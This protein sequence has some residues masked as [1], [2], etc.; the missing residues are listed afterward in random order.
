LCSLFPSFIDRRFFFFSVF[1]FRSRSSK[2]CHFPS[3]F[4]G[5]GRRFFFLQASLQTT[6]S[7]GSSSTFFFSPPLRRPPASPLS[8][9][10]ALLIMTPAVLTQ[11]GFWSRFYLF[12]ALS[13]GP[14]LI[15]RRCGRGGAPFDP[16]SSCP[17]MPSRF[18]PFAELHFF[19]FPRAC[20][21]SFVP[22]RRPASLP[23]FSIPTPR[24]CFS[25]SPL[26][27]SHVPPPP[28]FHTPAAPPRASELGG[29]PFAANLVF[30][31]PWFADFPTTI[32][33]DLG[34]SRVNSFTAAC[35]W[36]L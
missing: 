32:R 25:G 11:E 20:G 14:A 5:W 28:F 15:F 9:R 16:A 27:A 18:S 3:P 34:P 30:F 29:S 13:V 31:L 36:E 6:L 19:L 7:P 35:G 33:R 1:F 17:S 4:D 8:A 24:V 10:C 2:E 21:V 23:F 22:Q 26:S 12:S